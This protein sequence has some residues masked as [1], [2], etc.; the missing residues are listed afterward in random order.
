MDV[1]KIPQC[2]SNLTEGVTNAL[3]RYLNRGLDFARDFFLG[4]IDSDMSGQMKRIA[5]KNAPGEGK[6]AEAGG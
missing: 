2:L 4:R 1:H 3:R 5:Y 6:Q